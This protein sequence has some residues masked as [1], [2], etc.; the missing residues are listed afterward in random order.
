MNFNKTYRRYIK[1]IN[2]C[3]FHVLRLLR[4]QER[5]GISRTK[6]INQWNKGRS[7]AVDKVN[8]IREAAGKNRIF[9]HWDVSSH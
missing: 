5:D 2:V 8:E 9:A 3:S 6:A 7:V 1:A 4:Q